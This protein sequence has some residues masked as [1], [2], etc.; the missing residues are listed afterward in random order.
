M[1]LL[2][3]IC[4]PFLS[5][6]LIRRP[7]AGIVC[8]FLQFT[9]IGW[10]PAALWAVF[11]VSQWRTD[12]KIKRALQLGTAPRAANETRQHKDGAQ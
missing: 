2:I 3:A 4:L 5:F 6:F 7:V 9:L 12:Q 8:L 11:S 1:R 10:I